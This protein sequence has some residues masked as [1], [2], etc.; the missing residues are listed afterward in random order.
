MKKIV[1]SIE[2]MTCSA[3]SNGLEKLLNKQ[4]GIINAS[5]NLVMNSANIEYDEK[6]IPL[7]D[8]NEFVEKAGFKS[9]GIFN[10]EREQKKDLHEKNRLIVLTIFSLLILYI[11]MS[12]M[13]GLPSIPFLNMMNH[14]INYAIC[15]FLITTIIL[16][17]CR[18]ILLNGFKSIINETPNMDILVTTGVIASY[19]F[20]IY[21][22]YRII[23]G[24]KSF[25]NNLYFESAAIVLFF[26]EVGKY[27][28]NK[29]KNKTKEALQQLVT[30][31]P[32]EATIVREGA[33]CK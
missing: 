3:C 18:K 19:L 20:S 1:L 9:L 5:V 29:N 10:Y 31:T 21:G 27:I 23:N 14:P 28:E 4:D 7:N 30:I 8:L 24:D 15:L 25:V 22:T 6:K 12:H 13:I 16:I 17:L 26:I 11:S 33:E 2:G 32:K